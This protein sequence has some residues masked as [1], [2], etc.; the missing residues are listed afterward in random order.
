MTM[1]VL[2]LDKTFGINGDSLPNEDRYL[3]KIQPRF[4]AV[5]IAALSPALGASQVAVCS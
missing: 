3:D 2:V 5:A 1:D 4:A